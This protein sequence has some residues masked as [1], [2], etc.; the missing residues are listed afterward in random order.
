MPRRSNT[1][2]AMVTFA[3]E[4]ALMSMRSGRCYL[5]CSPATGFSTFP[6]VPPSPKC[7]EWYLKYE[8]HAYLKPCLTAH[9]GWMT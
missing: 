9:R 3:V 5:R 1:W 8:Y 4:K 2:D 6:A 7:A